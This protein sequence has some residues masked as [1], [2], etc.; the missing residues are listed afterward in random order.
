MC[1]TFKALSHTWFCTGQS[2]NQCTAVYGRQARTTLSASG[3]PV[4]STPR[5]FRRA[6]QTCDLHP[7]LCIYRLCTHSLC[8]PRGICQDTF[9]SAVTNTCGFLCLQ[10]ATHPV[11]VSACCCVLSLAND[12]CYCCLVRRNGTPQEM[13]E[14]FI[15]GAGAVLPPSLGPQARQRWQQLQQQ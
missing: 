8:W 6:S 13:S 12:M 10:S 15:G 5:V 7:A 4:I 1:S 3:E 9:C 14:K 2:R 11:M